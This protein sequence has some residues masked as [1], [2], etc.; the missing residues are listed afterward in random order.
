[1]SRDTEQQAWIETWAGHVETLGLS[2]VA[3]A[4]L[5]IAHA[6]GFLGSQVLLVAQPLMAGIVNDTAL[7][8]AVDLLESPEMLKRFRACLEDRGES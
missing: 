5:E 3:V 1:V 7:E 2:P 6:F 4:L 8:R